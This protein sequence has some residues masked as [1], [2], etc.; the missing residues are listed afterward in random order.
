MGIGADT[1]RPGSARAITSPVGESV[2]SG[3]M[4]HLRSLSISCNCVSSES[5]FQSVENCAP[6]CEFGIKTTLNASVSKR[7]G[8]RLFSGRTL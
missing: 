3:L 6:R 2:H 1:G 8:N 7:C 4:A 5:P